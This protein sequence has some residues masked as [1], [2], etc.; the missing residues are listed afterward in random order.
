[1][2]IKHYNCVVD[3]DSL[4]FQFWFYSCKGNY[5]LSLKPEIVKMASSNSR[6]LLDLAHVQLYILECNIPLKLVKPGFNE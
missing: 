2:N 5:L 4:T 6:V 3:T 1:M